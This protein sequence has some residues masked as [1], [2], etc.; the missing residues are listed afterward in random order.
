MWG[1]EDLISEI[2]YREIWK[3]WD[4]YN[5]P[6]HK[7][8]GKENQELQ[9]KSNDSKTAQESD[10]P[11]I[12]QTYLWHDFDQLMECEEGESIWMYAGNVTFWFSAFRFLSYKSWRT[13]L[14]LQREYINIICLDDINI[15]G[16]ADRVESG[17]KEKANSCE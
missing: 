2:I 8:R 11:S 9:E 12:E 15:R 13:W 14:W 16:I 1:K 17:S 7:K 4:Y 5:V 10:G 6:Q 3:L